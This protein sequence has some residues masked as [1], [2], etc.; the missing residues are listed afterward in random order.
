MSASFFLVM[1]VMQTFAGYTFC[2]LVY[3]QFRQYRLGRDRLGN[4][5]WGGWTWRVLTMMFAITYLWHL[6]EYL[7]FI[8]SDGKATDGP[9]ALHMLETAVRPLVGPLLMQLFYV[10]ERDR[11]PRPWL[12]RA[13]TRASFAA[14]APLAAAWPVCNAL[15]ATRLASH[16]G[17][18]SVKQV[19]HTISDLL[20][21]AGAVFTAVAIWLSAGRETASSAAAGVIGTWRWSACC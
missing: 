2:H 16:P 11:L 4:A 3:L 17:V 10:T 14:A 18:A 12:W 20:L 6:S 21:A 9:L 13:V 15:L 5:Q 7:W 19:V 8:F 1:L